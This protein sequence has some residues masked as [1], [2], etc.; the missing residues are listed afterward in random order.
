M[1]E[2]DYVYIQYFKYK[3]YAFIVDTTNERYYRI[4]KVYREGEDGVKH[5]YK[6][7]KEDAVLVDLLKPLETKVY[8][9]DIQVLINLSL[10]SGDKD[11]FE[12]L[13]RG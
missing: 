3:A 11:W 13:M 1:Q 7:V 4:V 5:H 8:P 12:E 9:E 2:G 6:E 10:D